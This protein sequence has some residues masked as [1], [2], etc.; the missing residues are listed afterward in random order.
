MNVLYGRRQGN[1]YKNAY[2]T[3]LEQTES[4]QDGWSCAD[5]PAQSAELNNGET[6]IAQAMITAC[7]KKCVCGFISQNCRGCEAIISTGAAPVCQA[8]LFRYPSS[9]V[10]SC[11]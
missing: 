4:I 2:G 11:K 8:Y 10:E 6:Q 5:A 3:L 7:K 9:E 1:H